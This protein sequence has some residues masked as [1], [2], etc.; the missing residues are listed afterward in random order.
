MYT[1]PYA[2]YVFGCRADLG[3]AVGMVKLFF[4]DQ[5]YT[6]YRSAPFNQAYDPTQI[7]VMHD[8]AHVR[9][10]I[11]DGAY[12]H[13]GMFLY[14]CSGVTVA[15]HLLRGRYLTA[16]TDAFNADIAGLHRGAG[17]TQLGACRQVGGACAFVIACC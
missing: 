6:D 16:I 3:E 11:V 15:A 17:M 8:A 7:G 14:L 9:S 4:Y 13:S 12:R 5:P 10:V 2:L 1:L